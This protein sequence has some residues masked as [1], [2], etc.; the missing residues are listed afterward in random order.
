MSYD[1]H[2]M[3]KPQFYRIILYYERNM[4]TQNDFVYS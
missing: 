4:A 3:L 2:Y 1:S